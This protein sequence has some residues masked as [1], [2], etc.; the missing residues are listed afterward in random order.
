MLILVQLLAT[1]DVQVTLDRRELGSHQVLVDLGELGF[2]R[3]KAVEDRGENDA[4]P[5]LAQR[6]QAMPACD[7]VVTGAFPLNDNRLQQPFLLDGCR[8]LVDDLRSQLA[9]TFG[10]NHDVVQLER[11]D[12]RFLTHRRAP[13][14]ACERISG[15]A[16]ELARD[17][18]R[19]IQ[20]V[21]NTSDPGLH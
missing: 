15:T 9:H 16:R 11:K 6:L 8:Q 17:R 20:P 3:R 2:S 5:K 18:R 12:G 1:R 21:K 13:A 19:A 4:V 10:R 14:A 7:Q